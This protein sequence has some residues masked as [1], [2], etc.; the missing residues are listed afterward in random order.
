M[1]AR[2]AHSSPGPP[3]GPGGG[4]RNLLPT[5][6]TTPLGAAEPDPP[7][8]VAA[9]GRLDLLEGGEDPRQ[10]LGRSHVEIA[11]TPRRSGLSTRRARGSEVPQ[12]FLSARPGG[13]TLPRASTETRRRDERRAVGSSPTPAS[14][15]VRDPPPGRTPRP[16]PC[17]APRVPYLC[18]RPGR[19]RANMFGL[20]RRGRRGTGAAS[21]AP[22]A[23]APPRPRA[24]RPDPD[25]R[26]SGSRRSGTPRCPRSRA[27]SRPPGRRSR[28]TRPRR[29]PVRWARR[30]RRGCRTPA[31]ILV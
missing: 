18:P 4:S 17:R 5:Q 15:P 14:S 22:S 19:P 2:R 25:G 6:S 27:A 29:R 13:S 28:R 26:T 30:R 1:S 24:A 20:S 16:T 8:R 21:R 10:S 9:H 23:D 7:P 11:R 31:S 3:S 12:S